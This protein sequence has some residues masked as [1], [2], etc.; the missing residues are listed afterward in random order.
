MAEEPPALQRPGKGGAQ[1]KMRQPSKGQTAR[2]GLAKEREQK[3]PVLGRPH[4]DHRGGS[5]RG[6]N[7]VCHGSEG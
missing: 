2:N 4:A 6:G 1:H 3:C 5:R 7:S